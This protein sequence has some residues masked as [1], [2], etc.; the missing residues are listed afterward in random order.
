MTDDL[1]M[2]TPQQEAEVDEIGA[3][4]W[5][6]RKDSMKMIGVFFF[7]VIAFWFCVYRS[8]LLPA[9]GVIIVQLYCFLKAGDYSEKSNSKYREAQMIYERYRDQNERQGL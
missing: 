9:V 4:A 6:L 1:P 7:G 5:E 2:L 8:A 3:E